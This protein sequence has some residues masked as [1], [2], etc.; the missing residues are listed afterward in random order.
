MT[1]HAEK[2]LCK[3]FCDDVLVHEV[4]AS[5]IRWQGSFCLSCDD[6]MKP[7]YQDLF[8]VGLE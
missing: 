3:I 2:I 8:H 6:Q 7:K 1:R 4:G 5:W